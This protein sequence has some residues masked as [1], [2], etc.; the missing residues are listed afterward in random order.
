LDSGIIEQ[1]RLAN[2]AVAQESTQ[3]SGCLHLAW[4]GPCLVNAFIEGYRGA[5]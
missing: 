1:V 2:F 4:M 5:A 3:V